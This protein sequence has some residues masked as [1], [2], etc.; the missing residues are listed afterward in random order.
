MTER[1]QA[2]LLPLRPLRAV[3][4]VLLINLLSKLVGFVRE[5]VISSVFGVSRL[6]DSF[7]ALQQFPLFVSNYLTGALNLAFVPHYAKLRAQ[8]Q[9]VRWLTNIAAFFLL[10]GIAA[11]LAFVLGAREIV[12]AYLHLTRDAVTV[13]FAQL[14]ALA[15][16]P[17]VIVGLAYN[18]LHGEKKHTAAM[19]MAALTPLLM[20]VALL[21]IAVGLGQQV[22]ALPLSYVI[23][24]G[25]TAVWGAAVLFHAL[26]VPPLARSDGPGERAGSFAGQAA[27][28]S[29]ENVAFNANQLLNVYFAGM[30]GVGG[31]AVY[32][33]ATR[34]AMLALNGLVSPITQVV[35]GKLLGPSPQD[36][37]TRFRRVLIRVVGPVV[38]IAAALLLLREPLTRLVYERGAFTPEDTQR[39][40]TLLVPYALYF[41]VMSLNQLLARYYYTQERGGRYTAA[42]L[43]GYLLSNALKPALVSSWGL[44]GVVWA[45]VIGEGLA[46]AFLLIPVLKST[47]NKVKL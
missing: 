41:A 8:G 13:G 9:H 44:P 2:L 46:L 32:T 21:V 14:L 25:G 43:A 31:P 26:R 24:V 34:L 38:L 6:T 33:F 3:R 47:R 39:V 19:G 28:A 23:G 29:I 1:A 35:Q 27:A 7:F 20:L 11:T 42:L 40:A 15:F 37:T 30:T 12:S 16:I 45:C 18:V 4:G 22:L 36:V 10:V 5:V 17:T